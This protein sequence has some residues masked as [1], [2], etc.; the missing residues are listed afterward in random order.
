VKKGSHHTQKTKEKIRNSMKGYTNHCVPR[1]EKSKR[2]QSEVMKKR[3]PP[4]KNHYNFG[5]RRTKE[6][7]KKMQLAKLGKYKGENNNRWK[8]GIW[9]HSAGY[10][11]I[12]N[13]HHPYCGKRGYIAEHRLVIEKQIKRFLKP[14]ETCHHINK[15]KDDNRPENLMAFKTQAVHNSFEA[16]HKINLSD[17]IFDGHKLHIKAS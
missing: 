5:K 16:G 4:G 14:K 12:L 2:K 3:F 11:F 10:V 9:K 7:R 17:I 13:P 15:I 8:G 6:A 1:S